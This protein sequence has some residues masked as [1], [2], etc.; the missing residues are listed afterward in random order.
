MSNK[1]RE[2]YERYVRFALPEICPECDKQ[3]KKLAQIVATHRPDRRGLGV[4]SKRYVK[5][6]L[7]AEYNSKGFIEHFHLLEVV[8]IDEEY[9]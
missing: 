9:S 2:S 8:D 6:L 4:G 1:E 7:A 5:V 3:I